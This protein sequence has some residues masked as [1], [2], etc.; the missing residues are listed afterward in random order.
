MTRKRLGMIVTPV[1]ILLVGWICWPSSNQSSASSRAPASKSAQAGEG[2][3]SSKTGE[4]KKKSPTKTPV[5][6]MSLKQFKHWFKHEAPR[7]ERF[8]GGSE[9]VS[10][11]LKAAAQQIT[12]EQA[13]YLGDFV[14][15][16][17]RLAHQRIL[18]IY[19]L[20]E[21]SPAAREAL[22]AYLSSSEPNFGVPSPHTIAQMRTGQEHSMRALAAQALLKRAKSDA[23]ATMDIQNILKKG[24]DPYT[25]SYLRKHLKEPAAH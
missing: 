8:R 9:S 3:N 22:A 25:R 4:N 1:V 21:G 17:R 11:K 15:N 16:P 23:D 10:G 24:D 6:K 20:G 12:A 13:D 19:L 7:F 18:A 2:K 5:S 14:K